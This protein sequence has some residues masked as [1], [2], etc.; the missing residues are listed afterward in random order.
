[1]FPE[2]PWWQVLAVFYM[3]YTTSMI[4]LL[5]GQPGTPYRTVLGAMEEGFLLLIDS[6]TFS[7]SDFTSEEQSLP[8]FIFCLYAFLVVVMLLNVLIAM[9][10]ATFARVSANAEREWLLIKV[11]IRF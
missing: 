1:M 6:H 9:M 8:A 11:P 3:C 4:V 2:S 7:Y 5:G 10:G